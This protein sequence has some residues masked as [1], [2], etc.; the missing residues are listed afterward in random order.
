V[1]PDE[2]SSESKTMPHSATRPAADEYASA[3]DRYIRLV[4]DS[5]VVEILE[6]QLARVQ[7][8]LEPLSDA[9]SLALHAPYTWSLKQVLGHLT[10]C[11]RI[12][13][14][15]ALRLGRHDATPLPG[16]DENQF[17]QFADFNAS[18]MAELLEE[19]TAVRRGHVLLLRH[20]SPQAWEWRG[21]VID[22]AM[23]PRALAYVMAGH[24]EHHLAIMKKR[25]GG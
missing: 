13:G 18:P 17:M 15:R 14:Y 2:L 24:V 8:L 21:T 11:E 6:K 23:T 20:L 22:H 12:F 9:Q 3:F 10:D 4:P 25:L 16:F 7:A 19:F 5:D 1:I